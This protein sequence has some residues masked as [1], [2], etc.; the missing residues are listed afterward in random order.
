MAAKDFVYTLI[1][2]DDAEP[3]QEIRMPEPSKLEDNIGCLTQALNDHYRRVAPIQG[4]A[5]KQAVIDSVRD[6]VMKNNPNGSAPDESMLGLLAQS[7]TVDIIQMLPAT[8]G[9]GFVGVNMYVDDKGQSK[10]SARN[11]RASQVCAACGI[12]TDVLGDA[13]VARVWDDQD[14]FERQ[15]IKVSDLSSDA[16]LVK[17]ALRANANRADPSAAAA[18]LSALSTG[19]PAAPTD[20]RVLAERLADAVAAKA[21]GTE[22]FKAGDVG[23]AAGKYEEAIGLLGGS[24][25]GEVLRGEGESMVDAADERAASDLLVTSLINLAMCRLKQEK[26]YEAIAAC[27]RALEGD[28]DAGKAWYRRGQACMALQQYAAARRN[29]S[30]AATLL[31]SSREVREDLAKCQAL[32]KEKKA[33]FFDED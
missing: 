30:R 27:D 21:A 2:A 11:A 32:A 18:Q 13:F 17:E 24:S 14:G 7:Q 9:S 33:G 29:L 8:K 6:Q 12:S 5:G 31:P 26:P 25:G 4:E 15:D 1:P 20:V 16:P 22:R 28:G 19:K 10:G 3:M 23:G